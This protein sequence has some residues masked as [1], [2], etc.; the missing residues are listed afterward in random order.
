MGLCRMLAILFGVPRLGMR[1]APSL[2]I[3]RLVRTELDGPV[4]CET[5]FCFQGEGGVKVAFLH[6]Q[7]IFV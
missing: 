3:Q 7:G 1:R 5:F 6:L 2:G 4:F